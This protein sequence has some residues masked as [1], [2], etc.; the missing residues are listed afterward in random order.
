MNHKSIKQQELEA[1]ALSFLNDVQNC[2]DSG[3]IRDAVTRIGSVIAGMSIG[4]SGD[5][6]FREWFFGELSKMTSD[7]ASKWNV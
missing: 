2:I 5:T 3:D 1:L 4:Q 7:C 6:A